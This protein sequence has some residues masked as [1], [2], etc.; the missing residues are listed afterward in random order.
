VRFTNPEETKFLYESEVNTLAPEE[1]LRQESQEIVLRSGQ[2]LVISET[3]ALEYGFIEHV[4]N[5]LTELRN[6]LLLFVADENV[7]DARVGR[8][9]S[10]FPAG[11]AVVNFFNEP[12]PRFLLLLIG[13][14]GILIELKTFGLLIPALVA[15]TSFL[16]FFVTSMLPVS[17][18]LEGTANVAELLLFLLGL[19]LVAIE[20]FLLPGMAVFAVSGA[21]LCAVSLVL[22]M[23]PASTSGVSD[24]TTVEDAIEI[25]AFG[26]G[27]GTLCFLALIRFLPHN[28]IFARRGLVSQS[29]IV[30][31]PTADSALAAQDTAAKLVGK[32]G[33]AL[34]TLRPAGKVETDEGELLD[35]VAEGE[36]I[37]KGTR[38]KV[39]ECHD[40]KILVVQVDEAGGT[41]D[42]EVR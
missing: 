17:G 11:Q 14:L 40:G 27:A 23:V 9:K 3:Q 8:L 16:I 39:R 28:P 29:S 32:L 41:E 10:R 25:L 31:V 42:S 26:F 33:R 18:S 36:F 38:V 12:L 34:S 30:G 1:S 5:D 21:A 35:V 37:E 24:A 20:F 15:L 2:L 4:A 13:C 7:I 22:A 19:A 6:R